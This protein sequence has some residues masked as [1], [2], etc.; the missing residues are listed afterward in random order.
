MIPT[1]GECKR[2]SKGLNIPSDEYFKKAYTFL[3]LKKKFRPQELFDWFFLVLDLFFQPFYSLYKICTL[4]ISLMDGLSLYRTREL[5]IEFLEYLVLMWDI[6]Y[7]KFMVRL[8]GGPWISTNDPEYHELVY[9]DAMTRL[10]C[11]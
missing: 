9:A 4:D 5:W 11:V 6:W 7:W 10:S 8:V 1:E 2:I 3:E